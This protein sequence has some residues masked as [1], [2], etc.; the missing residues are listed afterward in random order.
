MTCN[1]VGHEI[2]IAG[3]WDGVWWVMKFIF[4]TDWGGVGHKIYI[5]NGVERGA[6]GHEIHS[7]LSLGV[8]YDGVGWGMV[9]WVMIMTGWD[10]V[11]CHEIHIYGVVGHEINIIV[12]GVAWEHS[13]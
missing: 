7:M 9:R 5:H 13:W 12:G 4:I 6:V 1:G 8:Y 3:R 2:H 11:E 10:G